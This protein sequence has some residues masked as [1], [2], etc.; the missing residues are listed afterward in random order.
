MEEEKLNK[1]LKRLSN[2]RREARVSED[3][4]KMQKRMIVVFAS[5][6]VFLAGLVMGY[7]ITP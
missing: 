7:V 6:L 1:E 3:R 2:I 5:A 4:K